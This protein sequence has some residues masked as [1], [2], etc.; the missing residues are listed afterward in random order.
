M[1]RLQQSGAPLLVLDVRSE[2][3]FED[4][5][6][7]APGALRIPPDQAVRRLTELDVPRQTLLV[8]FCA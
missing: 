4:S 6:L 2:R 1:R 7:R 5:D 3:N 8:A